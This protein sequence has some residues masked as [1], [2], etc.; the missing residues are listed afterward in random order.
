MLLKFQPDG[1]LD[2]GLHPCV[3]GGRVFAREADGTLPLLQDVLKLLILKIIS[4][5][6]NIYHCLIE[7]C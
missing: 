7:I 2:G 5:I 1:R 3:R 4:W 6:V